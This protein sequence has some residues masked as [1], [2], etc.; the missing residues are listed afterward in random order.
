MDKNL[1]QELYAISKMQFGQKKFE[2][3]NN[4]DLLIDEKIL[5]NIQQ[6]VP[7]DKIGNA[8]SKSFRLTKKGQV[9]G[10]FNQINVDNNNTENQ[11]IQ[12]IDL[13]N[14]N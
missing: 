2:K 3:W 13:N 5:K 6:F 10:V 9:T 4:Y 11:N 7:V 8:H 12:E 1:Y 14:Y